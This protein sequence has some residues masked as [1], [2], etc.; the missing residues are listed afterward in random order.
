MENATYS[1]KFKILPDT[2]ATGSL[3]IAGSNSSLHV[4]GE[5]FVP[6]DGGVTVTGDLH[7]LR[8]VSLSD[9]WP[10]GGIRHSTSSESK[11]AWNCT[12]R[13]RLLVIGND[14]LLPND[15]EIVEANFT[16][17][18]ATKLFYDRD[19]FGI[20]NAY[21]GNGVSL[22]ERI[23]DEIGKLENRKIE[24]G[25]RPTIAYFSGKFDIASID[26]AIGKI[27]VFRG[28]EYGPA[29]SD[30]IKI[31]SRITIKLQFPGPV[32]SDHA[33]R[34]VVKLLRLFEIITGQPQNLTNLSFFKG[35][36]ERL[37]ESFEVIQCGLPTHERSDEERDSSLGALINPI[38][39]KE[40][41]SR[42]VANWLDRYETWEDAYSRF[43]NGFFKQES[44]D[45]DRLVGAANMFDIL[46]DTVLPPKAKIPADLKS[47]IDRCRDIV[48]EL[49]STSSERHS[50]LSALGR[51][52]TN[53]LKQ[54]I[55]HRA[56]I[57]VDVV[58]ND[59]P[60][61]FW[62]IDEAVNCR[63]HYVHGSPLRIDASKIGV[64]LVFF[65][66]TLEFVFVASVLVEAG[67]NPKPRSQAGHNHPFA[68]YYG[69][70]M[71]SLEELKSPTKSPS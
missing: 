29:N 51:V 3:T 11:E 2:Y 33:I 26:T 6:I 4:G 70:Y 19:A 61:I 24:S 17:D 43:F 27:S 23:T 13:P 7:D 35:E 56:K 32:D 21:Y 46:P 5:G 10:S 42:V 71:R 41:F 50:L 65:T 31:K 8:K 25:P 69:D 59:F 49:P 36:E 14:Y 52:A 55:R 44:Y 57:L 38:Q 22:M 63:N 34:N 28:I 30:G 64:A 37:A 53:T 1:G 40:E 18:D 15:K 58:G 67:W 62:V 47:V 45:I 9:C 60:E 48:K 16:F 54:K 12:L 68:A 20:V 39:H 66:M